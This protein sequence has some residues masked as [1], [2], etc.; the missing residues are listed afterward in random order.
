MR[1]RLLPVLFLLLYVLLLSHTSK[2]QLKK[3]YLHPKTAGNE[4]Q[5]RFIDS[6]RFIPLEVRNGS[7]F[8]AYDQVKVTPDYF[9][10]IEQSGNALLVFSRDGRFLKKILYKKLGDDFYPSYQAHTN[11]LVFFGSNKHFELTERDW[12]KIRKAWN[13]PRNKK[14]YRK[15]I[16]DL[17]DTTF[18]IRRADPEEND[19]VPTEHIYGD[20]FSRSDIQSSPQ[21][22]DSIDYEFRLYKG[23]QLHR[24]FFPYNRNHETK[25]LFA[26]ENVVVHRTDTPTRH[27]VS[28]P[29]NDTLYRMDADSLFP[30]YQLVL[31]VEHSLPAAF[32]NRPF[33]NATE[34]ENFR[35]NNGWLFCQLVEFMETRR[36]C[37]LTVM[38]FSRRES[39][40]YHKQTGLTYRGQ[41]IKPDSSHY[42]LKLL[43]DGRLVQY[44]S[45]FY[46]LQPAGELAA[47]F[48]QHPGVPVP[49]ELEPYLKNNPPD[50]AP[51]LVE[52]T[53]KN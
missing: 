5:S 35:E 15:Y 20:Y 45:R 11:Q 34:R 9:L 21:H 36:F 48:R 19:L 43:E 53:F 42:D 8:G 22:P 1:Y 51:V 29:Y 50:D 39:Y 49:K 47:F 28:R 17:A 13:N 2:A 10:I 37:Y 30:F 46:I 27:W 4:K 14:Y 25:Y 52:F 38:Y 6:I 3:I 31:P 40:V 7:A 18:T 33:R 24:M 41:N 23:W 12:Q 32:F 26:E 44:G 16:V